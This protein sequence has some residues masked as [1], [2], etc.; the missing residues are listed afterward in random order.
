M[1]DDIKSVF[2]T[3]FGVS[4]DDGSVPLTPAPPPQ[5]LFKDY[6]SIFA[7]LGVFSYVS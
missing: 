7:F 2:I 3:Y 6:F 4:E 5:L 1:W